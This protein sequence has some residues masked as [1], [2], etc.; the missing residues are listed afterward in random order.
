MT[1]IEKHALYNSLRINWLHDNSVPVEPWQVEDYRDLNLETLFDRL[2][3]QEINF[4]RASFLH[5]ADQVDTPE[6]LTELL[7]ENRESDTTAHDQVYLLIFELWRR[8]VPEKPSLSIFCD[9]LDHQIH[10]YD[11]NE[12][13]LEAIED[14]LATLQLILEDHEDE[15][16][17]P[18][19]LFQTV[20]RGCAN[21]LETF[22]Y[23]FIA[24]QIDGGNLS[25]ASELLEPFAQFVS[26]PKWFDFL[27]V[28]VLFESE[29][30][31]ATRLLQKFIKNSATQK[32]LEFNLDLLLFLLSVG[33]QRD[34]MS[35]VKKTVPLLECEQ[36]FQDLLSICIDFYHRLDDE[37]KENTIQDMLKRRSGVNLKQAIPS[38]DPDIVQLIKV[39]MD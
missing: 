19:Q 16:G 32:D 35:L 23:D 11:K 3:L 30:V 31:E 8:L 6:E 33:E 22:L 37:T 27:K 14:M 18:S 10:L 25:Y 2:K 20:C 13:N 24:E 26:D 15:G 34:F 9:E 28:Q 4:D 12:A 36:D 29:P 38:K 5:D 39:L 21:D 17:D 1:N 7:L